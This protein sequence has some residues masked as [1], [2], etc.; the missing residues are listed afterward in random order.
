V[1]GFIG[2]LVDMF[3]T[4]HKDICDRIDSTGQLD[5]DLKQEI[6]DISAK[7]REG[8]KKAQ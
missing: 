7:F 5:D 3:E 6:I 4:E 2:D 8:Y 1:N